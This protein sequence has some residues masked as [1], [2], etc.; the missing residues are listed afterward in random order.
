MEKQLFFTLLAELSVI[1]RGVTNSLWGAVLYITGT[2]NLYNEI[3]YFR[4]NFDWYARTSPNVSD[5]ISPLQVYTVWH[6]LSGTSVKYLPKR[7]WIWWCSILSNALQPTVRENQENLSFEAMG[8]GRCVGINASRTIR[9][10]P[11]AV[12]L[13]CVNIFWL[14][15]ADAR[16]VY[17]RVHLRYLQ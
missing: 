14:F 12:C 7:L 9:G 2:L 10:G 13:E 4:K 17:P 11:P 16:I 8:G 5:Y 1:I 6:T 3:I 15:K